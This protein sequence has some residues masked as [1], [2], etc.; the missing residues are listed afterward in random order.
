MASLALMKHVV[1][2]GDSLRVAEKPLLSCTICKG[3][4]LA[5]AQQLDFGGWLIFPTGFHAPRSMEL[6]RLQ[7]WTF[8]P[9]ILCAIH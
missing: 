2:D 3:D 6:A 8:K 5:G 4:G 9:V 7:A 1:A